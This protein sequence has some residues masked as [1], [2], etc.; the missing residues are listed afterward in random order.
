MSLVYGNA[1]LLICVIIELMVMRYLRKEP[2]PWKEIIAN[3]NSGHILLWIFRSLIIT[4]YAFIFQN[5]SLS[6]I[7]QW[8]YIWKWIFAFIAWDFCFYWNH[9]FHHHFKLL[10]AVHGVHHDGEHFNLSLGIRNSW[11]ASLTSFPFFAVL[12]VIGVPLEIFIAVSGINYFIGFYNHTHLVKKSGWL[13]YI[14]IT[15]SH[16]RVHHGKNDIYVNKNFGGTFVFW[17]K[18]FN[19]FQAERMDTPVHFGIKDS[20]I[21]KNPVE[22]SNSRL[23]KQFVILNHIHRNI[24]VRFFLPV[25][26]LILGCFLLFSLLLCFIYLE[27]SI[28]GIEKLLLFSIIFLGTIGSGGLSEGRT[29]GVAVWVFS[30]IILC[31]LFLVSFSVTLPLFLLLILGFMIHGFIVLI[32]SLKMGILNHRNRKLS[33]QKN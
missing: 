31:S 22:I 32:F 16:H 17:D 23:L 28:Q 33:I 8:L 14:L 20:V 4:A 2:I 6:L 10:W 26:L 15:P 29:W 25:S 1:L 13:E 30:T 12:A 18:L 3:I 19:T 5:L 11:Y 27:V 21:S 24:K 9:R 7:S